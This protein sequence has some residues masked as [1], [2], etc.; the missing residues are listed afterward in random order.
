[1]E[2][3]VIGSLKSWSVVDEVH[4]I[5]VPT[6]LINGEHDEAQPVCVSP[7]FNNIP[8]VKWV[9]LS[10]ASHMPNFEVRDKYMK[11]VVDFLRLT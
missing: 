1:L 4:K 2:F 11:V 9:T 6:L 5:T 3:T 8:K 10:D 7:F